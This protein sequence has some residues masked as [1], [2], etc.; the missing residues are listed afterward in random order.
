MFKRGTLS[1]LFGVHQFLWHP[2]TVWRAWRY[3]YKKNPSAYELLAIIFHDTGYVGKSTMDGPNGRTHPEGGAKIAM[4]A[5]YVLARLRGRSCADATIIG[6]RIY[7]L[8]LFH[9]THYAQLK[10]APVSALYLPDKVCILF[11]PPWF[12]KLR[13]RLSG[14]LAEY[15]NNENHARGQFLFTADQWLTQYREKILKKANDYLEERCRPKF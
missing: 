12:Y 2:F 8:S 15:V 6:L 14:E 1:V 4:Y 5:A 13:A 11:D 9:S 10:D 7:K 3:L